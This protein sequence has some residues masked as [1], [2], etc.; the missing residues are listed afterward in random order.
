MLLTKFGNK[1][2]L[3][4]RPS[5]LQSL[6]QSL[7]PGC[8][9][10]LVR[11]PRHLQQKGKQVDAFLRETVN[12]LLF[13]AGVVCLGEDAL[14]DEH[15]QAIGEDVGRDVFLGLCQELAKMATVHEHD[16]ADDEQSGLPGI[17]PA[18]PCFSP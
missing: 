11:P 18:N 4:L 1:P 9:Q 10:V 6:G 8:H 13:V 16:V 14:P 7:Q 15:L 3:E 5:R 17:E 2:C 12:R